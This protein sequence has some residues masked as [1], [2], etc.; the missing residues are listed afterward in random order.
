MRVGLLPKKYLGIP[1][2]AGR[3]KAEL[4]D[5]L[6]EKCQKK[7]EGW[8]GRWLSSVGR[9][10]MLQTVISAMPIFS[11]T[12]LDLPKKVICILEHKMRNFFGMDQMKV[13][14]FPSL[15]GKTYVDPRQKGVLE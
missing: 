12:C 11:M 14:K 6:I 8:K 7:M 1:F 4:W 13:T 5:T 2:F 10:L 9:I 3:N 15:H